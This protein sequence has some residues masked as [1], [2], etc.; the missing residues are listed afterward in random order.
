MLGEKV[1]VEAEAVAIAAEEEVDVPYLGGEGARSSVMDA[2]AVR[3][4]GM[5]DTI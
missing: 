2:K 5:F 3:S 1:D 4:L